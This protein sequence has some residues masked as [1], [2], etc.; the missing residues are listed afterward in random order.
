[1]TDVLR[2]VFNDMRNGSFRVSLGG[3]NPTGASCWILDEKGND[4]LVGKCRR[5]VWYSKTK[6][7]RTNLPNDQTFIKFAVGHAMEENFQEHWQRQ[8]VML[9]GNVKVRQDISNGDPRG[10]LIVSGEID[11]LLRDFD[12]DEEGNITKIHT[13]RGIGIEMKTNRGFFAKKE[14][15]GVG[16]KMY[17]NG[18]PKME[19]VMQTAMYLH[20]RKSV[21]DYYGVTIDSFRIVYCQVD[22]GLTTYFDVSL[23][24]GYDGEII[25]KDCQGNQLEPDAVA[26]LEAGIDLKRVGGLTMDNIKDRYYEVQATLNDTENPPPRDFQL[27]YDAETYELKLEQ[28]DLSKTAAGNWEKKPNMEV[29]DW[30]CRYCDWKDACYPYG[31]HSQAV[32]DGVLTPEKALE[33]LGISGFGA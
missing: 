4:K 15:Y 8:G 22:D 12:L 11:V 24:E 31:I 9:D 1:M 20:M 17:P 32:D 27:R 29:G 3:M 5:Q 30:N 23:S 7:P 10:E 14:I 28:G 18:H 26:S 21:E 33:M 13:D 19:H 2:P 25:I 16:N 6:V